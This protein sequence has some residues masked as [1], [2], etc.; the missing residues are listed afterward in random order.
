MSNVISIDFS[1]ILQEL[2]NKNL[3]ICFLKGNNSIFL[4]DNEKNLY[5]IESSRIGSYLD[6]LI[7]NG[8]SVV[9]NIVDNDISKNIAEWK[10]EIWTNLEIKSFTERQSYCI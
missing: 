1:N 4:E 3:K 6:N 9:F 8:I 2:E 10:R 5:S 7:R